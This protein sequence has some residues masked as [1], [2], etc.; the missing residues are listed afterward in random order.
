[1]LSSYKSLMESRPKDHLSREWIDQLIKDDREKKWLMYESPNFVGVKNY[2][3]MIK[4]PEM[5]YAK[6]PSQHHTYF[7]QRG[8]SKLK[9]LNIAEK[10]ELFEIIGN[11]HQY[12]YCV[13]YNSPFDMSV[14]RFHFH[15]VYWEE[16][17]GKTVVPNPKIYRILTF[18]SKLPQRIKIPK[19]KIPNLT[20]S[21]KSFFK[22]NGKIKYENKKR[23]S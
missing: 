15:A 5:K 1:M 16:H 14:E 18:V 12:G 22:K 19:I 8:V 21:Q 7:A 4:D 9:N 11:L 20:K 10:I 2:K 17:N 23:Q 13:Y 3:F 6:T